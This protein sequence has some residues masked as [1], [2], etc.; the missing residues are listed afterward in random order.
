MAALPDALLPVFYVADMIT[1]L[2][3]NCSDDGVQQEINQQ[4][5]YDAV[6]RNKVSIH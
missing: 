5:L 1:A 6:N 2:I 4:I 3:L